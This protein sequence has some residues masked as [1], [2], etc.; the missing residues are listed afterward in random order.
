MKSTYKKLFIASVIAAA[1]VQVFAYETGDIVVR[2]GYAAVDPRDSSS[3]LNVAGLGGKVAGTGVGVDG[4][5]AL[6]ITGSYM[7]TPHW[8][9]DCWHRHR[10]SMTSRVKVWAASVSPMVR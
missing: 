1:S 8:G 3:D 2:A 6:G 9:I 5:S 7:L 4:A 10:S